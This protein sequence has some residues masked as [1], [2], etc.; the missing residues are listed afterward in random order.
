MSNVTPAEISIAING[1]G[2]LSFS[3]KH[4]NELKDSIEE[5]M[6]VASRTLSVVNLFVILLGFQ[7]IEV[8]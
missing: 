7:N 5:M 3:N 1:M 2:I 6:K 4:F 8:T